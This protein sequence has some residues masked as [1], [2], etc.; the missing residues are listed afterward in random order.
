MITNAILGIHLNRQ[1]FL[2]YTSFFLIVPRPAHSEYE[3]IQHN[4]QGEQVRPYNRCSQKQ[5]AL[6]T[7]PRLPVSLS[8]IHRRKVNIYV[9]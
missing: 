3:V 2:Q 7:R 1:F 8:F 6:F 9:R 4:H 5:D